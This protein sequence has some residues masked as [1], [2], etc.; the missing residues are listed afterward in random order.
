M[1]SWIYID[2]FIKT[3]YLLINFLN[4]T[5]ISHKIIYLTC[6]ILSSFYYISLRS[7]SIYVYFKHIKQFVSHS[8]TNA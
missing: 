2:L 4:P 7:I 1:I 8:P 6:K 5:Q 3:D